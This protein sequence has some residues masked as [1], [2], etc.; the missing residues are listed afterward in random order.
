VIS[1]G[2]NRAHK[3]AVGAKHGNALVGIVANQHVS[4][5]QTHDGKVVQINTSKEKVQKISDN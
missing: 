4:L 3:M 1:L 5:P 2:A